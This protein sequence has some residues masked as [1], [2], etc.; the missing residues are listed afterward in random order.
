MGT[1]GACLEAQ[2][3]TVGLLWATSQRAKTGVEN[4]MTS[5][6]SA[7][8][9]SCQIFQ[10]RFILTSPSHMFLD[11]PCTFI[12]QVS[13]LIEVFH[14]QNIGLSQSRYPIINC[15]DHPFPYHQPLPYKI[16]RQPQFILILYNYCFSYHINM[17]GETNNMIFPNHI[18]IWGFQLI[19]LF[20]IICFYHII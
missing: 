8:R 5:Q 19:L 20:P 13:V 2:L 16:Y 17:K 12:L 11:C 4:L 9:V 6:S 18:T 7:D 10:H 14:P 15:L 1:L 3:C